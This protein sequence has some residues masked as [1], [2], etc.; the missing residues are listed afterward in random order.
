MCAFPTL[1]SFIT[2]EWFSNVF[3]TKYFINH[4]LYP[5]VLY[6]V[7][8]ADNHHH[9]TLFRMSR[10]CKNSLDIFCYVCGS[11]TSKA[12]QHVI[13]VEIKNIY[14]LYFDFSLGDQDKSWAPHIICLACSNKLRHWFNKRKRAILFVVSTIWSEPKDNFTDCYFCMA[15]VC[16]FTVKIKHKIVYPDLE[17]AR[18]PVP[19]NDD[20]LPIP[21][22][23]ENSL[24]KK[25]ILRKLLMMWKKPM[26]MQISCL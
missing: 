10:H 12:Q 21:I 24:T 14:R 17:S 19:H 2:L 3:S 4:L 9:Q 26:W 22:S 6:F 1:L 7:F 8:S 16:G 25:Y 11:F 23:P 13:T 15:N 5:C 18:R 20:D